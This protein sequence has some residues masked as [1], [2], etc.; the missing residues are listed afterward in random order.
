[1]AVARADV[2]PQT[3]PTEQRH[4]WLRQAAKALDHGGDHAY[5]AQ[6][7]MA[8]GLW[9]RAIKLYLGCGASLDY[10]ASIPDTYRVYMLDM[11]QAHVAS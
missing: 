5:A 6:I 8:F 3:V 1:V 7:Y 4:R 9:N 11:V 2:A 10:S